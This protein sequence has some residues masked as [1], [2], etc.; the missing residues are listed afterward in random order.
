MG[1]SERELLEVFDPAPPTEAWCRRMRGVLLLE[2]PVMAAFGVLVLLTSAP[3]RVGVAVAC[4]LV[5]V[6]APIATVGIQHRIEAARRYYGTADDIPWEPPVQDA[7]A[8]AGASRGW[9]TGQ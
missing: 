2:G 5:A 8:H 7:L 4:F 3:H 1:C 9:G 6:M